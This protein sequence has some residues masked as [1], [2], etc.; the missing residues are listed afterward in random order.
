MEN[1]MKKSS[2]FN[3]VFNIINN[4][5]VSLSM[6]ITAQLLVLRRIVLPQFILLALTGCVI[7]LI[8][9]YTLPIKQLGAKFAHLF[10]QDFE[11]PQGA[12]IG[13]I[14]INTVYVTIISLAMTLINVGF[15]SYFFFAWIS[16]YPILWVVSYIVSS[17]STPLALKAAGQ[18]VKET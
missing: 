12:L 16:M 2:K 14:A 3:L 13:N 7:A 8:M 9:S 5:S 10:K 15:A 4:L 11:M 17:L 1:K 6:C 18:A